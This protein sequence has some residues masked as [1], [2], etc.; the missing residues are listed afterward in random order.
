V[1]SHLEPLIEAI[2]DGSHEPDAA[3]AAHL[4]SCASCSA[5]LASA[6]EIERL[7]ASREVD[8]PQPS[9]TAAVMAHVGQERWRTERIVDIGFNLFMVA[10]VGVILAG[11]A[12]LAWSLGMLSVSIDFDVLRQLFNA[13]AASRV[14]TQAQAIATGAV[15]LTMALGVWW[16]AETDSPI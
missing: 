4:A 2:A 9:F 3:Q 1:T 7:L 12:G 14:L 15:I 13:D 16:W 6:R 5:K 11:L 8:A 10:G